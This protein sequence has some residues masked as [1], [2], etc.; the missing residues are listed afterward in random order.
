[1]RTEDTLTLNVFKILEGLIQL[2]SAIILFFK[3]VLVGAS[4][5][6]KIMIQK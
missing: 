3:D 2:N 4:H 6:R 1:M 5:K